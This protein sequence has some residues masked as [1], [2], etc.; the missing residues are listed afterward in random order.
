MKN[1]RFLKKIFRKRKNSID[2]RNL[3]L[4]NTRKG[5]DYN[6]TI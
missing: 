6:E 4:Y 5:G 1:F 2:F 3:N